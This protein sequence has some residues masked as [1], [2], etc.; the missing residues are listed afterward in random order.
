MENT[1]ERTYYIAYPMNSDGSWDIVERFKAAG[2]EAAN[3]Y[4]D[5]NYPNDDWYVLNAGCRNIN[6]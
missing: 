2:D 5:E 3:A 1:S 6:S 4:A